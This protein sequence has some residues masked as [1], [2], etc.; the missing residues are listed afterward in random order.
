MPDYSGSGG[1]G[2]GAANA[3]VSNRTEQ[4]I[5]RVNTMTAVTMQ[6]RERIAAHANLL[7]YNPTP[8]TQAH[9]TLGSGTIG[10]ATQPMP[11]DLYI[12]LELLEKEVNYLSEGLSVLD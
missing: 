2:L 6:S 9:H 4:L 8:P 7:G 12:A 11:S 3:K 1:V 5:H 10:G